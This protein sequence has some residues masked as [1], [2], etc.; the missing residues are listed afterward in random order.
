MLKTGTGSRLGGGRLMRTAG[1]C[2]V[3]LV[4]VLFAAGCAGNAPPRDLGQ[5]CAIRPCTCVDTD[6][7]WW[8]KAQTSEPLWSANGRAYCSEG[9]ELR[10]AETKR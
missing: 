2:I 4:P 5:A 3:V 7:A 9:Y 10:L 8:R 6:V 1:L